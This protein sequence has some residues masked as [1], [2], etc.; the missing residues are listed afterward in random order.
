MT[1][2][3]NRPTFV[4]LLRGSRRPSLHSLRKTFRNALPNLAEWAIDRGR[5]ERHVLQPRYRAYLRQHQIARPLAARDRDIVDRLRDRGQCAT[6]LESLEIPGYESFVRAGNQLFDTLEDNCDRRTKFQTTPEFALLKSHLEIFQWA[7][8]DRLLSIAEN[9]IELPVAYDTCLCNVSVNNGLE[10]ATRRWHLDNEDRRVLKV[11]IYFSD[12]EAG[13]GPFQ[14]I[15]PDSSRRVLAGVGDRCA[16]LNSPQFEA[17]L[18]ARAPRAEPLEYTGAAGTVVFADTAK[19]YHR[20][21]PPVTRARRAITF[22][23]CSRRP[24]RPFR[25]GRNELD[26]AQLE[27][28]ATG[29]DRDR[30]ACVLWKN[31]LPLLARSIPTYFY[32]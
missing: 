12:V 20:G 30:R 14:A 11:I 9:Y 26:R 25:C 15:D 22:G 8:G 7:L 1:A 4:S 29:L 23:Y 2:R 13:G 6:S 17:L 31:S 5:I 18:A 19:V 28:L 10:T 16:F 27:Q 24:Q 21:Q 3:R 32:G